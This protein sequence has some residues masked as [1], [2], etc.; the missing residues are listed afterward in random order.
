[1]TTNNA[2]FPIDA[3][4]RHAPPHLHLVAAQPVR[5]PSCPRCE[6][7][8]LVEIVLEGVAVDRC[9]RCQGIWLDA[10]ELEA[11]RGPR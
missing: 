4:E 1:M 6:G 2:A 3:A 7:P 9:R 10:G 11:L 8:T 5:R